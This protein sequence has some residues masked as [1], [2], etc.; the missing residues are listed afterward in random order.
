MSAAVS[1]EIA[2]IQELPPTRVLAQRLPDPGS[3]VPAFSRLQLRL[4]GAA[5]DQKMLIGTDTP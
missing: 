4:P 2:S 3:L 5:R 1:G